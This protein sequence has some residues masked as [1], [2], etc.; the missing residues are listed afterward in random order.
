[1]LPF[2]IRH[3]VV[4]HV[5]KKLFTI[6]NS[7]VFFGPPCNINTLTKHF[8]VSKIRFSVTCDVVLLL[9]FPGVK[10][11]NFVSPTLNKNRKHYKET[12]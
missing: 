11:P 1:M 3:I 12:L 9:M 7:P 5:Q 8:I 2:D 4:C 6:K 10:C